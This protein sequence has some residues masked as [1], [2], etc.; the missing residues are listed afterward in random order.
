MSIQD[1]FERGGSNTDPNEVNYVLIDHRD[2]TSALYLH[3]KKGSIAVKENNEVARGQAIGLADSSGRV[4]GA[5][6][7]FQ[8]EVTPANIW[9]DPSKGYNRGWYTQSIQVSFSDKDVLLKNRTKFLKKVKV[10][11]QI[12]LLPG[13]LVLLK[14]N[15]NSFWE[16]VLLLL[17]SLM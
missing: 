16:K 1:K 12:M 5:H 2:G 17:M 4:T 15:Q 8:I 6:L 3:L 7:H 13:Q 11:S 10:I 9:Y 14:G